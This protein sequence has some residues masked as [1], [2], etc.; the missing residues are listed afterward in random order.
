LPSLF[1]MNSGPF[2]KLDEA[3]Q[4]RYAEELNRTRAAEG[5]KVL[6][7]TSYAVSQLAED[8]FVI[9]L[10]CQGV[11]TFKVMVTRIGEGQ[12]KVLRFIH[13]RN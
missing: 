2:L 13:Q 4:R 11:Q 1:V 9:Q 8:S 10:G 3:T 5:K 6:Q 7:C 12:F